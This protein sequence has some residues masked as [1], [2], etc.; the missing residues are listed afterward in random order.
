MAE[1]QQE[2]LLINRDVVSPHQLELAGMSLVLI[3]GNPLAASLLF[4]YLFE[5]SYG[6]LD[7]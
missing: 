6:L 4:E 1:R 7:T 2:V 5:L 3:I